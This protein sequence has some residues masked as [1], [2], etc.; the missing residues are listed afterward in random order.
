MRNQKI[1]MA[2]KKQ[3]MNKKSGVVAPLL[4]NALLKE[5][6]PDGFRKLV[7]PVRI[8]GRAKFGVKGLSTEG[9]T[10]LVGRFDSVYPDRFSFQ[11]WKPRSRQRQRDFRNR[12]LTEPRHDLPALIYRLILAL[13]RGK[14]ESQN[15]YA[16]RREKAG[17]SIVARRGQ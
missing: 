3:L 9:L 7:V 12:I 15:E 4:L 14:L 10:S 11:T 6:I 8:G 13:S 2:K 17:Y 1:I 5:W 16:E